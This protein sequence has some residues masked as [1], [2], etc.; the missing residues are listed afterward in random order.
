M[1]TPLVSRLA[2]ATSIAAFAGGLATPARTQS[3]PY[4]KAIVVA[5][6]ATGA[7]AATQVDLQNGNTVPLATFSTDVYPPLAVTADPLDG[8]IVVAL[9]AGG[10]SQIMRRSYGPQPSE[11]LVATV[12][13]RA[14]DVLIDRFGDIVVLTTGSN[15]ALERID[16]AS[17]TVA[18]LRSTPFAT[19][20]GAPAD[21]VYSAI[22]GF[23][24]QTTPAVDPGVGH[25]DL[26]TGNWL[27]GP[28]TFPNY[29]PRGIVGLIDLP[30]AVPRQILAHDDGSLA[31]F[32]FGIGHVPTPLTAVPAL[33]PGGITAMKAY[34][35]SVGLILG[36]VNNPY[37]YSFDPNQALSGTFPL[38]T[39][40]GPLTDTPVDYV[41]LPLRGA[42][43][44]T[45]G[46]PCGAAAQ[47]RTGSTPGPGPRLGNSGFAITVSGAEPSLL[48][49]LVFGFH[50]TVFPFPNGCQ[51]LISVDALNTAWTDGSG[52]ATMP[53]PLPPS[54]G[55]AGV[56]FFTQWL[57][58]DNGAPFLTSDLASIRLGI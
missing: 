1:P 33:P 56:R 16:R 20:A 48:A 31:L 40:A 14:A 12:P 37:I 13:G 4:D 5:R 2:I 58:A 30:T 32:A 41:V 19:A 49:W 11:R 3:L 51:L 6:T 22:V 28:S 45:F 26:D 24:G 27:L 46:R 43:M 47:M 7:T 29:T 34:P 15:G 52:S 53:V 36:G 17:G 50:E 8:T 38:T 21:L 39:I 44:S 10:S 54:P 23:S 35:G 25:L 9:D 18:T 42:R 57:Q 55:L